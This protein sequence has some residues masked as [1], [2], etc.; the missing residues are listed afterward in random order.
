M[1]F[2][3][4]ET[5]PVEAFLDE[6]PRRLARALSSP[7]R[8]EVF[9][10]SV[11][12]PGCSNVTV[13]ESGP[14]VYWCRVT[15]GRLRVGVGTAWEARAEGGDRFAQMA[16]ARNQ[17][18]DQWSTA[19]LDGTA[20]T[21][22][23]F[24]GFAFGA[25]NGNGSLPGTLLWVP[26]VVAER[27]GPSIA[28]HF[29]GRRDEDPA[30]LLEEWTGAARSLARSPASAGSE[31]VPAEL[32][33][34]PSDDTA[35][36]ARVEQA[37]GRI[38]E[39]EV[40]KLVLTRRVEV[41]VARPFEL[42]RVLGW[43]AARYPAGTVFAV[44][45][46]E[47]SLVGVSPERLMALEGGLVVADALAGSAPR[48]TD[49]AEDRTLGEA[50][51]EDTKAR[52]EHALVVRGIVDALEPVCAG[53]VAP[54]APSLM[55]LPTVQHLSTHVHGRVKPEADVFDL[56]DRLHPTPAVG[57]APRDPALAWL[58]DNGEHERGWYTG[59]VGWLD[60]SGADVWVVLRCALLGRD[61]ATLFAGAGIVEGSDPHSE[62]H[63]TAW[64]LNAILEALALG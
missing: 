48:G 25:E 10:F 37:L 35:W 47:A 19:S 30:V 45:R 58:S 5:V 24:L 15:D 1:D 54:Q 18:L 13:P 39:G 31:R 21:R 63:E 51:L 26:R 41:P 44:R 53:L 62:F 2:P 55:R 14:S 23:A 36:R 3:V 64:K 49:A 9:S 28:L 4:T 46:P 50:L 52:S 11:R 43:L 60:D 57:G 40:D 33:A 12:M 34:L 27:R 16:R 56:I 17:L 8:G 61:R 59:G 20:P 38:R 6:L 42:D 7:P 32:P 29:N 22:A